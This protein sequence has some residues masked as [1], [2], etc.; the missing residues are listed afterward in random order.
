MRRIL[1]IAALGAIIVAGIGTYA[2]NGEQNQD[3]WMLH[4][5]SNEAVWK[6]RAVRLSATD[7]DR[8]GQDVEV[9]IDGSRFVNG[10]YI[11]EVM[12][13]R[14]DIGGQDR[15]FARALK[16]LNYTQQIKTEDGYVA[17]GQKDQDTLVLLQSKDGNMVERT[18]FPN[19][20]SIVDSG[21][22]GM[23]VYDGT[24]HI[25]YNENYELT[26]QHV[27]VLDVATTTIDTKKIAR[28]GM[29]IEY[30]M[31]ETW[32]FALGDGQRTTIGK[33]NR[34]IPIQ[35][36]RL[37]TVEADDGEAYSEHMSLSGLYV[38]DVEENR[39]VS[40][41]VEQEAIATSVFG[42]TYQALLA[43]GTETNINLK[44]LTETS[45]T[46]IQDE[47]GTASYYDG[48][49]YHVSPTEDGAK[50][51][52]YDGADLVSEATVTGKEVNP[53]SFQYYV[54]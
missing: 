43:D 15:S 16:Q 30:V 31:G 4:V 37:E 19:V 5:D 25:V 38:Y 6:N 33:D 7:M 34:Y 53:D 23:F 32:G 39:V 9:S 35:A 51:D 45:R 2:V 29:L 11:D 28:D 52:V 12:Q 41:D 50:V 21:W 8:S 17:I 54:Y 44:T 42:D 13:Y 14:S 47:V 10:S 27:A 26:N 48:L 1:N 46:I 40:L 49:L 18:E 24:V 22:G 3:D 36:T 20:Q